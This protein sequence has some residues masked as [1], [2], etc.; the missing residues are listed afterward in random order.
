MKKLL[1]GILTLV[2]ATGY[3]STPEFLNKV[4]ESLGD[5]CPKSILHKEFSKISEKFEDNKLKYEV[6]YENLEKYSL[7][8]FVRRAASS[9]DLG[10][11][12]QYLRDVVLLSI[13]RE[14]YPDR[15]WS[16]DLTKGLNRWRAKFH[17]KLGEIYNFTH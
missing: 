4:S 11:G 12:E 1:I 14:T 6:T 2:S 9:C 10:Y 5:M 8:F 17:T 7:I 16:S 15:N 3:A 13:A